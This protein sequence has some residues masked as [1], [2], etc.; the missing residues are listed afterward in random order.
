LLFHTIVYPETAIM[1]HTLKRRDKAEHRW[2]DGDIGPAL[3]ELLANL[4][5]NI[6]WFSVG[7]FGRPRGLKFS[8]FVQSKWNCTS[9]HPLAEK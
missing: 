9:P 4:A 6:S 3:P 1:Y 5:W 8:G 2:N 7:S